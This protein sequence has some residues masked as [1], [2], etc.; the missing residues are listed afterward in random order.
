MHIIDRGF[1]PKP[2]EPVFNSN[3]FPCIAIMPSGRWLAAFKTAIVKGDCDYVQAVITWSDDEGA[4]W[5]RPFVPVNLP[6][7]DGIPGQMRIIGLLPVG[8]S[9]VLMVANWVDAS[10]PDAPYYDPV[11]E[12]LKDTRIFYCFSEDE[13]STWSHPQLM[14]T[15]PVTA[16]TPLTGAPVM[17]G[18]GTIVCQFEINKSTRDSAKWVHKSAVIFSEDQGQ[19]WGSPVIVTEKPDMYYWDQRLNVMI[20]G[21]TLVDFFWTLDGVKQQYLNIHARESLDGGR[22]WGELWDTGIY[23]QPGQPVA[24]SDGR[25][26][27]IEIDRRVSPVITV[28]I[29]ADRGRSFADSLV[30]YDAR[31][32]SQDSGRLSMNDA[33][34]EMYAFSVGHPNLVCL[35]EHEILAYYYAG[36]HCDHTR[37][38]YVYIRV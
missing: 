2:E 5:I 24:L 28:R 20:D 25:L 29:S 10:R 26:A 3:T 9:R 17:L 21:R 36:S 32:G 30:I 14:D 38:E 4:T 27:A 31:Q 37:I 35:S 11:H 8:G 6:A 12:T 13:G 1:I 18:D 19:T 16:P 34:D 22:S 15:H 23:G 33:W 7:I